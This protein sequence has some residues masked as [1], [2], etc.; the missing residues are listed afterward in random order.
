MAPTREQMRA[1]I[2]EH[3]EAENALALA[4][5]RRRRPAPPPENSDVSES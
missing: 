5:A 3:V 2:I 4:R 1:V